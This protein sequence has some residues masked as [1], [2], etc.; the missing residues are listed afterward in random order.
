MAAL[1]SDTVNALVPHTLSEPIRGRPGGPLAG[2]SFVAKDLYAIAGHRIANGNPVWFANHQPCAAHAAAVQRLLDAGA[3]LTGIAI[4]DE[5]F[6]SL[7]G[8]NAHYGSPKNPRAPGRVTGGSSCG[9]AAAVAAGLCDLALGSDTGGS[10]RIPAAF[11]GLYG[12]RP[13]HGRIDATGVTPMAPSF[14]TVGHFADEADLFAT[15]GRVL[16]DEDAVPGE[17]SRLLVWSEGFEIADGVIRDAL[18]P[19]IERLRAHLPDPEPV[20]IAGGEIDRWRDAFRVLQGGEIQHTLLPFLQAQDARLGPGIKERFAMAAAITPEEIAAARPVRAAAR[21]RLLDLIAPGTLL[22]LPASATLPP[23]AS[24]DGLPDHE[25][26]RRRTQQLTCPAVLSG[27]PQVSLPA[28]RA[29][30]CPV[31]IGFM[32]WRGGDEA[33]LDLAVRLEPVLRAAA[34]AAA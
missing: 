34:P 29:Q 1:L 31:G 20:A 16:L 21:A 19:V 28:T 26:F 22:M 10:V 9:S 14:D 6:Y 33:L 23:E 4:C 13:T 18:A 30:G 15:A 32:A 3:E 2:R 27:L 8:T 24:V 25:A 12:L 5:F 17:V 11:C 7:L